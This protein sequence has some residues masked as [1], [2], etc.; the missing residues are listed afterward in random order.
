MGHGSWVMGYFSPAPPAQESPCSC[1]DSS[2]PWF[3][4]VSMSN[5]FTRLENAEFILLLGL[6]IGLVVATISKQVV[7][8][9]APLSLLALLNSILRHRF[10]LLMRRETSA[11]IGQVEQ[12][13]SDQLE[14]FGS[15]YNTIPQSGGTNWVQAQDH[16]STL[17]SNNINPI[18]Q[19][20][21]QLRQQCAGLQDS[22]VSIAH[23]L[24][25]S[26]PAARIDDLEQSLMRLS[27]GLA[28]ISDRVDI[29]VQHQID[30]LKHQVKTIQRKVGTRDRDRDREE[31]PRS[32]EEKPRPKVEYLEQAL[33][34]LSNNIAAIS[35]Q[36]ELL[37]RN[38]DRMTTLPQYPYTGAIAGGTP[39]PHPSS[40]EM[41]GGISVGQSTYTGVTP[42]PPS[43]LYAASNRSQTWNC[44]HTLPGH[45]D[46]VSAIAITTDGRLITG[47][48]DQTLKVW[49]L[50][51]GKL[52]QKLCDRGGEIY[53]IAP[54][55]DGK[56][57]VTGSSDQTIKLWDIDSGKSIYTFWEY[58]GSVRSVAVSPISPNAN[59][60]APILASGNFDK[61]VKLWHLGTRELIETLEGH[62]GVV[63]AVAFSP[64]PGGI[65]A[66]GSADGSIKIWDWERRNLLQTF[67][68]DKGAIAAIAFSPNGQILASA[69]SDKT[70]KLWHI[71]TG[72]RIAVLKGH[73][74]AVT[75]IVISPDGEILFSGSADGTIQ[76][77][78]LITGKQLGIL[79]ADPAESVISLALSR[80]GQILVSG[81]AYGTINIWQ[82]D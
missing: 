78:H 37:Q 58:S 33:V 65:L 52:I 41:T 18:Y 44:V 54:M 71:P 11:A 64:Y 29:E 73:V 81:S 80:D 9:I 32:L 20:L 67:S 12:D 10:E 43:P 40:G 16:L 2:T 79:T 46:W 63:G 48:F 27:R 47:S 21:A 7:Y 30:D 69:S 74:G 24:N 34:Q 72:K 76:I 1:Y 70:V 42:I 5:N 4:S 15:Y 62:S 45:S 51:S 22:L 6:I 38:A 39:I 68:G 53:A 75:S 13:I 82:R 35:N 19:D 26:S 25:Q 55:Q 57:L 49:N 36:V 66:S 60:F 28:N 56:T 59:N 31:H 8:A 3:R 23:Y 14:T 17:V 77:W 61:T 50:N